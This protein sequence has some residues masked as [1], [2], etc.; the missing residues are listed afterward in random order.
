MPIYWN[1]WWWHM[2]FMSLFWLVLIV[3]V[4]WVFVPGISGKGRG[5]DLQD[6]PEQILKRRYAGGDIDQQEYEHRL[7]EL[8]R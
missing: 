6:S 1:G 2:G 4:V 3:V 7:S 8:R 5:G